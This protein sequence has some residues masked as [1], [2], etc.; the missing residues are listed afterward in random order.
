MREVY[1]KN[2]EKMVFLEARFLAAPRF[3]SRTKTGPDKG[4]QGRSFGSSRLCFLL[5][6]R[7]RR[8]V[9]GPQATGDV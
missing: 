4:D 7:R 5:S 8:F 9:A 1:R 3:F 2:F 6:R